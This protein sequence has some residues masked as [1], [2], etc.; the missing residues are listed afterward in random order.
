M[1]ESRSDLITEYISVWNT[2]N[3]MVFI[4]AKELEGSCSEVQPIY[5]TK[6]GLQNLVIWPS[7][8]SCNSPE[9]II[10]FISSN[11]DIAELSKS[12]LP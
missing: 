2:K 3:L 4:E 1:E 12:P 7:E 5:K 10:N 11:F 8:L 9:K 6:Y